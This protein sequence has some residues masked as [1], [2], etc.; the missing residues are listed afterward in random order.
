MDAKLDLTSVAKLIGDHSRAMMLNALF[1]V[2]ALPASDLAKRAGITPQTASSHLYKLCQGGLLKVVRHGR[3]RYYHLASPEVVQIL[4]SFLSLAKYEKLEDE[5]ALEPMYYA[6]TCYDHLAG[7]LGVRLVESLQEHKW[8]MAEDR[9]FV[10][11]SKGEV[12]FSKLGLDLARLR[13]KRRQFACQCLDWT[14]RKYHMS[15]ALG[16]ALTA[17]LLE[18]KWLIKAKTGRVIHV[19][20]DGIKGFKN[21]FDLSL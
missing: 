17:L 8:F 11:T 15:G 6:R 3:H 16:A 5:E 4:E 1:Y 14:E 2:E 21:V 7:W 19:T 10:V 13:K 18:K 20:N 12:A 9:N